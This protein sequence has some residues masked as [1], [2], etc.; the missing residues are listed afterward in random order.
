MVVA[1]AVVRC[2]PTFIVVVAVIPAMTAT[3]YMVIDTVRV[4]IISVVIVA[5]GF[6]LDALP[7]GSGARRRRHRHRHHHDS[8][9]LRGEQ[10]LRSNTR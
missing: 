9:A 10:C 8:H 7:L 2:T 4:I 3:N 1:V 6:T 5:A